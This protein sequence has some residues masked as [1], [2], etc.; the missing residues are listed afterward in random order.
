MYDVIT[1]PFRKFVNVL[2]RGVS[3]A[4]NVP[5]IM[6]MLRAVSCSLLW[7]HNGRDGVSNHQPHDCLLNHSFKRR[8]KKTPKLRVT[9]LYEGNSSVTGE[10]PA[11]M[12]SSAENVSISWRHH[13]Y[14]LH[15]YDLLW[16]P[17]LHGINAKMYW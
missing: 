2:V 15:M 13:A 10:I 7:R 9:G 5:G 3:D 12:A 4:Q 1:Y 16:D 6:D 17:Y 8:L 11:Q 14:I